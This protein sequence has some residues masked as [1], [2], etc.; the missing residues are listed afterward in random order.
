MQLG[1]V[2]FLSLIFHFC[3]CASS[4]FERLD[5][6]YRLD[7]ITTKKISNIGVYTFKIFSWGS[8]TVNASITTLKISSVEPTLEG[9]K[10]PSRRESRTTTMASLTYWVHNEYFFLYMETLF[11][12][13]FNTTD[14]IL[15]SQLKD[16]WFKNIL[17]RKSITLFVK[18]IPW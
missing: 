7:K 4:C 5:R 18:L 11:C 16:K 13:A 10:T 6:A 2:L 9:L 1:K 17:K 15:C 12:N 14:N 3:S 8:L